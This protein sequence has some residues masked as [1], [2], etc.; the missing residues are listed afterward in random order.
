MVKSS[1]IIVARQNVF[2]YKGWGEGVASS[3]WSVFPRKVVLT[4][5]GFLL[6]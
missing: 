2:D 3:V 1:L 4:F 5:I 6:T